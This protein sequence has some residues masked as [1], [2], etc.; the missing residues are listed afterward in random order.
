LKQSV[1][2]VDDESMTRNLLRLMLE[3]A[4]YEIWEAAD[5]VEALEAV[6]ENQPDAMILDV[7]MPN[8]DGIAVCE[9]LRSEPETADLP[10]IMLSARTHLN[11]IESGLRAGATRYLSKPISRQDLLQNVQEVIE[12][13]L[14]PETERLRAQ[15]I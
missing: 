12:G 4:G 14:C 1:L 10:V 13:I 15:M 5:G 9:V 2:I 6:R 8:M 11:A 3:R 7:M